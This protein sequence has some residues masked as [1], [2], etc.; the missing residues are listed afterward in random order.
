MYSAPRRPFRRALLTLAL[1]SG[2]PIAMAQNEQVP[3]LTREADA[4]ETGSRW[5]FLIASGRFVPTG[6][7]RKLVQ[8]ADMNA[9]QLAYA[10]RPDL[11]ITSTFGWA[12]SRDLASQAT[13]R[14]D[15]LVGD[16]GVEARQ[17]SWALSKSMTFRPFVGAGGGA[18]SYRRRDSDIT[19][20]YAAQAYVSAGGELSYGQLHLRLD[21]RDYVSDFTRGK[22]RNDIVVML[23]LRLSSG[24]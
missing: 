8:P 24:R 11:A 17:R 7:Q 21:A 15:V 20:T 22:A 13:P 14:L 16:I 19:S 10:L 9:A 12:R 5:E 1:A 4:P 18:R 2:M 3:H 23:G 6:A